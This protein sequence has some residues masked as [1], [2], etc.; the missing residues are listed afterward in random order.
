MIHQAVKD[1]AEGE[2]RSKNVIIFG[3]EEQE[4]ENVEARVS[5]ILEV[6]GEK[7]RPEAVSRMGNKRTDYNRPVIVKL[8]NTAAATGVLRKAQGLRNNVRGYF[9]RLIGQSLRV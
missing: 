2:E 6:V 4:E 7:P 3:L 1:I 5:E 9:Y 8:R